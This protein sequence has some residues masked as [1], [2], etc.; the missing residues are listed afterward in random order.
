MPQVQKATQP[1]YQLDKQSDQIFKM[2]NSMDKQQQRNIMS[3]SIDE[4]GGNSQT[5]TINQIWQEI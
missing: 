4:N 5:V 3:G 1:A 2:I